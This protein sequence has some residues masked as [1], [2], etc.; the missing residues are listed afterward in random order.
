MNG[1][2]YNSAIEYHCIP[3]FER[4]GPY[5]RKCLDN[6]QWSGD[7]PRCESMFGTLGVL[8]YRMSLIEHQ[9]TL[10]FF[11]GGSFKVFF[12]HYLH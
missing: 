7:Q 12:I 8:V 9:R 4:I 10:V 2:T 5:L 3:T 11:C 6:G 1:T